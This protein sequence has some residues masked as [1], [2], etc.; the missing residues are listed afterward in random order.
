MARN[1]EWTP[2]REIS[3]MISKDRRIL[4]LAASWAAW[5]DGGTAAAHSLLPC[6]QLALIWA[7]YA[8]PRYTDAA[9]LR[10]M[11]FDPRKADVMAFISR[12]ES[13]RLTLVGESHLRLRLPAK[14]RKPT[15]DSQGRKIRILPETD[16]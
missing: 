15:G 7:G 11:I 5:K 2:Y 4:A 1:V 10:L 6:R 13:E 8:T 3:D 14:R 12:L 9:D 16:C